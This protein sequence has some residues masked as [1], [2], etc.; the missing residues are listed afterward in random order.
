M[1]P[2]CDLVKYSL[3]LSAEFVSMQAVKT[4]EEQIEVR[5]ARVHNLKNI[6]VS[7]PVNKLTVIT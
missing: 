1:S 2:N 3:A 5:G 4:K 7:F 6:S